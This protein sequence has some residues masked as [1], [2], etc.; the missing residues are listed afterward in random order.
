[1]SKQIQFRRG[2]ATEHNTFTGA[3]GELTVDTTTNTV[4]VHDGLTPGGTPLARADSVPTDLSSADY[5]VAYQSSTAENN[6]SWYRRYKSGWIE[7]G[8]I[9]NVAGINFLI[10]FS[11]SNY[12]FSV[13]PIMINE[14]TGNISIC[15]GIKKTTGI[16]VQIRWNGAAYDTAERSWM[17]FGY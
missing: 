6:Y 15:Y 14:N 17:A 10:P 7:Q 13:T 1:M 8:G 4:R 12:S 11:N 9:S 5:V 3:A 2:T 16:L